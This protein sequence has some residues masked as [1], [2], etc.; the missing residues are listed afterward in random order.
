MTIP[1]TPRPSEKELA[2]R[3]KPVAPWAPKKPAKL[4]PRR[5]QDMPVCDL[6]MENFQLPPPAALVTFP[7]PPPPSTALEA[8]AEDEASHD[9]LTEIFSSDD[10]STGGTEPFND[11]NNV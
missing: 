6:F 9:A 10:E 7:A 2:L 3:V 4:R 8:M 11:D 1:S 5:L